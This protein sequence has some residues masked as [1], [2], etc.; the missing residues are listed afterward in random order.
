[1]DSLLTSSLARGTLF[2]IQPVR[3]TIMSSLS[4]INDTTY[5]GKLSF[6]RQHMSFEEQKSVEEINENLAIDIYA[7]KRIKPFGKETI[8]VWE[9]CLGDIKTA[10]Q[11]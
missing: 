8:T 7:V 1:M 3:V 9:V 6:Y 5:A 10:P 4:L 11:N 2:W